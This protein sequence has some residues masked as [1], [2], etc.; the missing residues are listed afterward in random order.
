MH[1]TA[2]HEF[3][4]ALGFATSKSEKT[5]QAPAAREGMAFLEQRTSRPWNIDSVMNYCNPVRNGRGILSLWDACAARQLYGGN[6]WATDPKVFDVDFYLSI[7]TDVANAFGSDKQFATAHWLA[8]GLPRASSRNS[9]AWSTMRLPSTVYCLRFSLML[10]A[11]L[12]VT[13]VSASS[14]PRAGAA[15]STSR[16]GR[17]AS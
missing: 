4:H 11:T 13:F 10:Q 12:V 8:Y 1:S 17:R 6:G 15:R 2:V 5:H 14:C 7:Y 16:V 3:G 9:D